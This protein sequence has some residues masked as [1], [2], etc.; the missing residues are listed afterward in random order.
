MKKS[1][2][3]VLSL[4]LSLALAVGTAAGANVQKAQAET[5]AVMNLPVVTD[6][7]SQLVPAQAALT[8]QGKS[9][10]TPEVIVPVRVENAGVVEIAA[11]VAAQVTTGGAASIEMGFFSDQNCTVSAGGATTIAAGSTQA[12]D[13]YYPVDKAGVYYVRFKWSSRVPDSAAT[14]NVLGQ[15]YYGEEA[16]L[17][18]IFKPIYVGNATK[19]LY[20]KVVVKKSGVVVICGNEYREVSG[21]VQASALTVQLC[22]AKK[23]P[24]HNASLNTMNNYMEKYA[25]KKGTYYVAVAS[26]QR[27]QLKT[28]TVAWKDKGGKN[29]KKAKM[30]KKGK[31]ADGMITLTDSTKKADWYKIRLAKR[32][33]MKLKISTACTGISSNLKVQVIP[34]NRH[35]KLIN[36]SFLLRDGGKKL[37]SRG[38]LAAGT[39]YIKITKLT[40]A[41]SGGFRV[42]LMK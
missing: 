12:V 39:Y 34:A 30:I 36:N 35:Y 15:A 6:Y 4:V 41:A 2:K 16:T 40:K 32:S 5:T 11:Q 19:K 42:K 10:G 26:S 28:Q 37:S 3:K 9:A 21:G 33:K 31:S 14:I 38:N 1:L 13:K 29:K 25:L 18:S 24:L 7:A 17:S 22:N 27:Y 23:K 20:H 8:L